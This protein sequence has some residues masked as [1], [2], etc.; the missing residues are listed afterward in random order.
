[1]IKAEEGE[2]VIEHLVVLDR[3]IDLITPLM[4]SLVYESMIDEVYGIVGGI[5]QVPTE[6]PEQL[7]SV[8]LSI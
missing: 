4:K 5:I 1:M 6:K 7:E 8:T 3:S 2:G